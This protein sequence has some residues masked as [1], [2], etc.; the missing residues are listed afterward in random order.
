IAEVDSEVARGGVPSRKYSLKEGSLVVFP[1]SSDEESELRRLREVFDLQLLSIQRGGGPVTGEDLEVL[2]Y[3]MFLHLFRVTRSEHRVLMVEYGA[4][5]GTSLASRVKSP[6]SG[7]ALGAIAVHFREQ[8]IADADLLEIPGSGVH[9]LVS[10][11]CIGSDY[12]RGNSC[13]FLEGFLAG[14]VGAKMGTQVKVGRLEV[15]GVSSC[16]L[17]VGRVKKLDQRWLAEAVLSSPRYS[18]IYRAGGGA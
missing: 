8:G 13:Y 3:K 5:A 7:Q 12:H 17:A 11:A 18:A 1:T 15:P 10:S 6:S 14:L 9:V 4:R 16:C 2:L